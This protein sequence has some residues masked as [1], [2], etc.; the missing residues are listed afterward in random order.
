[1]VLELH[2]GCIGVA[3]KRCQY[4]LILAL[5]GGTALAFISRLS[6]TVV[7]LSFIA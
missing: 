7:R 6:H 5:V 2:V 3:G 4:I 1:M